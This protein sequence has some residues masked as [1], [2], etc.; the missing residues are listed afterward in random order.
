[1]D[2]TATL[3]PPHRIPKGM[4]K[5]A[6]SPSEAPTELLPALGDPMSPSPGVRGSGEYKVSPETEALLKSVR[7]SAAAEV[8]RDM[9]LE[10]LVKEVAE[11]TAATCK[12]AD[13][14]TECNRKLTAVETTQQ[15]HGRQLAAIWEEKKSKHSAWHQFWPLVLSSVLST[16]IIGILAYAG[17]FAPKAETKSDQPAKTTSPP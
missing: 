7:E 5:V 16:A 17:A 11:G 6:V 1:M 4:V 8:R 12:V 13:D 3:Q 10:R 15:D 14:V 2:K 9:T